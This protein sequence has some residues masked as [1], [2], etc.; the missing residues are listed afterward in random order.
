MIALMLAATAAAAG[1]TPSSNAP[2]CRA[3]AL[4]A[5]VGHYADIA[6][7]MDPRRTASLYAAGGVLVGPK[8]E[9]VTGP[10]EIEAFLAGFGGYKLGEQVMTV[11]TTERTATGWRTVGEF[12]QRG[13]DPKNEAFATGG[14]YRAEWRCLKGGWRVAR[15][16]TFAGGQ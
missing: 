8:A 15:M 3:I 2:R 4:D 10:K 14:R 5:A 13:N 11:D 9:P 1:E 16:Q 6:R 7:A 12:R